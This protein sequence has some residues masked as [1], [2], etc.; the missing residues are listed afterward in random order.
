ML[1][2]SEGGLTA[3]Q[4]E[5]FARDGAVKLEQVFSAAWIDALREGVEDNLAEPGP[6]AKYYTPDG[7][8]GFFFGDYCNWQ[9]ID[10]YHRFVRESNA[11]AV[12]AYLMQSN[13][14]NF[15]HEHVLV[16]EPATSERTPWH[17]DQP[18][19][20]VDGTQVCS[21]WVPLD[22]VVRELAVEFVAGSHRSGAWYA[23]KSFA[24]E[25][26][27]P[28][29]EGE[30]VPDIDANRDAFRLLG[31]AVEPGDCVAFHARTVHGAPGNHSKS[32]R[33]RAVAMR[34]T[35]DDARFVRRDGYMS[36]P[37]EDVTLNPGAL[38]DSEHFPVVW[39]NSDFAAVGQSRER[40]SLC[41]NQ[42]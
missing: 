8:G 9:R 4:R 29:N 1:N 27:H 42:R 7:A 24:T 33:R 11:G 23:P 2:L 18:Y 38:M 30:T 37:F 14:V 20:V 3:Q 16:K 22:P 34:F 35:G 10:G 41:N 21:L 13:K 39:R 31:W 40:K 26:D 25:Q 12:A 32:T 28:G 17:H 15:F 19:W 6:Y 36:P 5:D